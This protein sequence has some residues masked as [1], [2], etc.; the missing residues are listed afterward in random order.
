MLALGA[1]AALVIIPPLFSSDN[2]EGGGLVATTSG[3][4]FPVK[5]EIGDCYPA[6]SSVAAPCDEPHGSQVYALVYVDAAPGFP[7][8]GK[9]ELVAFGKEHCWPAFTTYS[10][11]TPAGM[12]V[13]LVEL[14]PSAIDW[15]AG[16]RQVLCVAIGVG[17]A[18]LSA[19]LAA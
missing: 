2:R 3:V 11:G 18:T 19:S 4:P 9:R 8:P 12:G 13:D 14:H 1:V 5:H 7:Y 16:I 6:G 15:D 10:S 17:G